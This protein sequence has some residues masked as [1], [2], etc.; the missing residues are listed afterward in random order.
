MVE[1]LK[2][3]SAHYGRTTEYILSAGT[4][5]LVGVLASALAAAGLKS[6]WPR[7]LAAVAGILLLLI[8]GGLA[9]CKLHWTG[10]LKPVPWGGPLI[11]A[12]LGLLLILAAW[13]LSAYSHYV[14][15]KGL[16]A[17]AD[18]AW[19]TV[20]SLSRAVRDV[21]RVGLRTTQGQLLVRELVRQTGPH[22]PTRIA[23]LSGPAGAGK[24]TALFD[25]ANRYRMR[26]A[27]KR[28]H[29]VIP[30]YVD[31]AG[32]AEKPTRMPLDEYI[33]E[34]LGD[35]GRLTER[36]RDGWAD[37]GPQSSWL[38]LFDNADRMLARWPAGSG[39][40]DW[41]NDLASFLGANGAKSRAVVASR[42]TP[43]IPDGIRVEIAPLSNRLRGDFLDA[44][45]V[46]DGQQDAIRSG[47]SF[48]QYAGNP[49]WL[50]FVSPCLGG[51]RNER[52]GNFY[53]LMASCVVHTLSAA[54]PRAV[55]VPEELLLRVAQDLAILLHGYR[56][57][58][59]SNVKA[60]LVQRLSHI[61][62]CPPD[63]IL[64]ALSELTSLGWLSSYLNKDSQECLTFSHDS[65]L[66]YFAAAGL[67]RADPKALELEQ[68]LTDSRWPTV[69]V[70]LL[71]HGDQ[72]LTA[73][74]IAA[75]ERILSDL[76][77]IPPPPADLFINR[78]LRSEQIT[79]R[80]SRDY[81]E[82]P[83]AWSPVAHPVLRILDA[84]LT[85]EA[86][87]REGRLR[88]ETDRL[89]AGAFPRCAKQEQTE[90]IY[91]QGLAHDDVAA[92]VCAAGISAKD[93]QM[94]NA[95]ADQLAT[96]PQLLD[97]LPLRDRIR[98]LLAVSL[99]GLDSWTARWSGPA[100]RDRLRFAS[101]TGVA[102]AAFVVILIGLP[103]LSGTIAHP[104][105]WGGGLVDVA[106]AAAVVGALIAARSR[107]WEGARLLSGGLN[108]PFWVVVGMAILGGAG[109]LALAV[110]T[111]R[112]GS[113]PTL[114]DLLTVGM[115]LWPMSTLYYLAI[116]P[117]PTLARW[118]FP[119]F[120]VVRPAWTLAWTR[121]SG[122]IAVPSKRAVAG[123][124]VLLIGVADVLALSVISGRGWQVPASVPGPRHE[125]RT[126]L[127]AT[128]WVVLVAC[129]LALPAI[130]TWHDSR[131]LRRWLPPTQATNDDVLS[132]LG[133]AR[134]TTGT[135]A[136]LSAM[137]RRLPPD[138]ARG[139][140]DVIADLCR[141]FQVVNELGSTKGPVITD[142]LLAGVGPPRTPD[143]VTWL[144]NYDRKHSGRLR[145]VAQRQEQPLGEYLSA[146][147]RHSAAA[148]QHVPL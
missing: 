55:G 130:D 22:G 143:F 20:E 56:L 35:A 25:L 60:T 91:V 48:R 57:A 127:I 59:Y 134:T 119:F 142:A 72:G 124:V 146:V 140:M 139:A 148:D 12:A 70:S 94:V 17:L 2:W 84:G 74:L 126:A 131:W 88:D 52:L 100:D 114:Q 106:V 30:V 4:A 113:F 73:G 51:Q 66:V 79:E 85:P 3:I 95:A 9:A 13:A 136:V 145:K 135:I 77:Q 10:Q 105:T 71:Q 144:K 138:D 68:L 43:S 120:V 8:G 46:A 26:W 121:R 64:C 19:R 16:V 21:P 11:I 83:P 50:D 62:E 109:L 99:V 132:W 117:N 14:T 6:R 78:F 82:S 44:R 98:F 92:A 129:F 5:L 81:V 133:Q 128:C 93:G 32:L 96:R 122:V 65:F 110:Q 90:I 80:D 27:K 137:E 40:R 112:T 54:E 89:I 118:I 103:G 111:V 108:V 49:G 29:S 147:R 33:L 116:E 47:K 15:R 23:V 28:R 34:Q 76:T 39:T 101:T 67:L 31:L 36:F 97:L 45:D 86:A 102:T 38:F 42:G 41:V 75:A 37:R 141:V 69:A 7:R 53:D 125:V 24:T 104:R 87:D 1:F 18:A 58:D 107:R 115:F 61:A 123:V 63:T